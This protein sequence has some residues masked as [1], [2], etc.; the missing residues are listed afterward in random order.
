MDFDLKKCFALIVE[1]EVFALKVKVDDDINKLIARFV[2]RK[3]HPI[4]NTI[5]KSF[6]NINDGDLIGF[7]KSYFIGCCRKDACSLF[8]LSNRTKKYWDWN[9]FLT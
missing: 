4:S 9:L 8:Q 3:C 1:M 5:K 6:V 7:D 2:G